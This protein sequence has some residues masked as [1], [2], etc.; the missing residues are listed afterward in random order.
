MK[1]G[2]QQSIDDEVAARMSDFEAALRKSVQARRR[3]SPL[4]WARPLA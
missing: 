3:V 1:R 2:W 4:T